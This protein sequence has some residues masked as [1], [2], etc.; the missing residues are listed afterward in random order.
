MKHGLASMQIKGEWKYEDAGILDATHLRF[1]THKSIMELFTGAG[2]SVVK[3][4]SVLNHK[5]DVSTLKETGNNFKD[6]NMSLTDLS[7]EDVIKLLTYQYLV[8]AR[9]YPAETNV[10]PNSSEKTDKLLTKDLISIIILTFNALEYTR[11]CVDS[12]IKYTPEPH[13]VIFVDNNSTDGTVNWLKKLVKENIHYKLL[14]NTENLGFARGCNQGIEASSGEYILLLNN[15]VL[16]TEEWLSGMLECLNSSPDIGI[17][18]PMTN[19]ISGLQQ[20]VDAD[21]SITGLA[22]YARLF[23]EKNRHRR[24]PLQRI[25]GFCML[26]RREL[27]DK[28]GLLDESFG[29]GNFEDDDLCFRAAL[30]GYKNM[31]AGD[32]FLHHYGSRSFIENKIPY[33]ALMTNNKKVLDDKWRNISVSSPLGKKVAVFSFFEKAETY[34]QQQKTDLAVTT[35]IEGIKYMPENEVIYFRLAEMFIDVERFTE[36]IEA[37]NAMPE[38][39]KQSA[40]WHALVGYCKEGMVSYDEAEKYTDNALT[41]NANSSLALNLKGKLEDKK[42]ESKTAEDYFKKAI[43]SDPGYGR[44][45]TNLGLLKWASENKT[46]AMD[47]LEKGFILSP[48]VPDS[49][50]LYHSAAKATGKLEQAENLFREIKRFYPL[51]KKMHFLFIDLLIAQEKY[52]SAMD[53]TGSAMVSYGVDEG[54]LAAATEMR[55]KVGVPKIGIP[56][57]AKTLSACIIAKNEEE[58]LPRCLVNLQPIADEIIL[59]DTGSTDRTKEIAFAF[60][61]Q[62]FDF[63]W[64]DDFSLARNFSLSEANGQWILVHDADEIISPR[65]YDTLR[66]I[67]HKKV[68]KPVAYILTTRNYTRNFLLE[69]WTA[70]TGEYPEEEKGVGWVASPKARLLI[71]DERFRFVNPIHELLEP[72]LLKANANIIACKVPVHHYGPLYN[73]KAASK[74]EFYYQLGKKKLEETGNNVKAVREM[75]TQAAAMER[76]EEAIKLWE[77]YIRF[78]PA[79]NAYYSLAYCYMEMEQFEK[80]LTAAKKALEL[81]RN[82]TEAVV[83]YANVSLYA[84]DVQDAISCL[85]VLLEKIPNHPPALIPLIAAYT[86]AGMEEKSAE[87]LKKMKEQR[88]DCSIALYTISKKLI[89]AD[90][91][92]YAIGVLESMVKSG[93][94][95]PRYKELLEKC[96][97][98]QTD[99]GPAHKNELR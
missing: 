71:N 69:G 51:D 30:E 78:Y 95:N 43:A 39:G 79:T 38:G 6:G 35:L 12:I 24:I 41:L 50:L 53:E 86:M 17:I 70:N 80:A 33:S 45:Y 65:D 11:E 96:Y 87:L 56:K 85:E 31:I 62:V 44:S 59:V 15:D 2:L 21:Y 47:Y 57:K 42:G 25:V 27:I 55:N 68:S 19:N 72:S 5:I 23:R 88:Y 89:A 10:N 32:V 67:I 48:T 3:T 34:Y 40:K 83:R 13:E 66:A 99:G 92:T 64:T 81:D 52:K 49:I 77:E 82:S 90:R 16:V 37:L 93:Y 26:F 9:K 58:N 75:A 29:T 7:K 60:G 4:D 46:E 14:P 18:G 76:Y 74:G 54:I 97:S 73:E 36:A 98:K 91:N 22:K 63:P 28:V 61:A 8:M 94:K 1:F 84:G 20:I